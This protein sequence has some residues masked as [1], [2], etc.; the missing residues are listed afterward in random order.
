MGKMGNGKRWLLSRVVGSA[1]S[2]SSGVS[3]PA[4]PSWHFSC[5]QMSS[6]T[7]C[8][9]ASKCPPASNVLMPPNDNQMSSKVL[10]VG[11]PLTQL[12]QQ[13][14]Q[15]LLH[16]HLPQLAHQ[17]PHLLLHWHLSQLAHQHPQ[18]HWH[19]TQ[20]ARRLTLPATTCFQRV[21]NCSSCRLC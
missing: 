12:A 9:H 3:S 18:L 14:P 1:V 15:L 20:L 17:H 5:L 11:A 7:Q 4:E 19:L 6:C 8:P 16:W 10:L 21:G 2:K 13:H